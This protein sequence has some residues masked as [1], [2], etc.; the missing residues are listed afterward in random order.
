MSII[1]NK[2]ELQLL[3]I[4]EMKAI[5]D[6][7]ECGFLTLEDKG[8]LQKGFNRVQELFNEFKQIK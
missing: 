2:N 6:T 1:L 4:A 3:I 8:D 7:I 5:V